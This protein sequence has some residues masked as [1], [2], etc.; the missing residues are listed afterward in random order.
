V[1][2][3]S[4]PVRCDGVTRDID[5]CYAAFAV[6]NDDTVH[7]DPPARVG[8]WK[9]GAGDRGSSTPA[10]PPE[11]DS[12]WPARYQPGSPPTVDEGV[13]RPSDDIDP[14]AGK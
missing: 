5:A 9:L 7:L 4:Q 1:D 2:A 11:T 3:H 14:R 8:I 12:H 13:P 6:T 10:R